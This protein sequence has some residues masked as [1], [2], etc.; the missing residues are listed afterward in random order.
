MPSRHLAAQIAGKDNLIKLSFFTNCLVG[1]FQITIKVA[2]CVKHFEKMLVKNAGR[3]TFQPLEPTLLQTALLAS[4]NLRGR[5][6]VVS[7]YCF[8]GALKACNLRHATPD[9]NDY[10]KQR[11]GFLLAPPASPK[12]IQITAILVFGFGRKQSSETAFH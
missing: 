3:I 11:V 5:A 9:A 4:R 1:K 8:C 6:K 12:L 10:T 2:F 7:H